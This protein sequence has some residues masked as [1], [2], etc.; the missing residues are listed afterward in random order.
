[1]NLGATQLHGVHIL[2]HVGP[3]L[4]P[5]YPWGICEVLLLPKTNQKQ[6]F[7]RKLAPPWWRHWAPCW[8]HCT[9]WANVGSIRLCGGRVL[10]HLGAISDNG[11][12]IGLI[13]STYYPMMELCWAH[14]EVLFCRTWDA[15]QI[16]SLIRDSGILEQKDV[17][18]SALGVC[19]SH[20]GASPMLPASC[21][22][23]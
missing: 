18:P 2:P 9:R 16:K 13:L 10:P 1:M 17:L 19:W 5:F 22:S 4:A 11:R 6:A 3:T 12:H 15:F 14:V 23:G 21:W 20:V 8:A 7:A